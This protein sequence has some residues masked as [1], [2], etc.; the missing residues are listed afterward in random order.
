MQALEQRLEP[1]IRFG[2]VD[3]HHRGPH[4]AT[5]RARVD[6][7]SRCLASNNVS[8]SPIGNNAPLGHIHFR[9]DSEMIRRSLTEK[10]PW[11]RDEAWS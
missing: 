10:T 8:A 4:Q 5:L 6:L 11:L 3:P 1:M 9:A 2:Q 7:S